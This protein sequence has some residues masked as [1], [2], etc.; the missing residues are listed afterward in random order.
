MS[1]FLQR[2]YEQAVASSFK[3]G[4]DTAQDGHVRAS[5]LI[6]VRANVT[7]LQRGFHMLAVRMR[8]PNFDFY[9]RFCSISPP[10]P[11]PS[12]EHRQG[13]DRFIVPNGPFS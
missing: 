2:T 11:P 10:P 3:E 6:T 8:S 4:K 1:T 5:C 9:S 7:R 13:F 12:L